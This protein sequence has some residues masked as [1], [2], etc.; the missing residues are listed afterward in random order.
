METLDTL[1]KYC[2]EL[3]PQVN[4]KNIFVHLINRIAT[5]AHQCATSGKPVSLPLFDIFSK[6]LS[7]IVLVSNYYWFFFLFTFDI[8]ELI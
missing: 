4:F 5:H 3:Q 2:D 8:M 7:Q 1:L 6:K